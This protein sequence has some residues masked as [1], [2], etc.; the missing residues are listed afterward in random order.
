MMYLLLIEEEIETII[1]RKAGGFR[2]IKV[3]T[4]RT[5]GRTDVLAMI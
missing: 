3:A 1:C 5:D 2:G 4:Q